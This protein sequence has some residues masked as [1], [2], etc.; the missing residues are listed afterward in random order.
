MLSQT[1]PVRMGRVTSD[2]TRMLTGPQR[3]GALPVTVTAADAGQARGDAVGLAP[4]AAHVTLA[5]R[6]V[7]MTDGVSGVVFRV[8]GGPGQLLVRL[9]Y[10]SFAKK[11]TGGP[12]PRA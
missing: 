1:V 6:R 2:T 12:G 10:A 7:D 5:P 3:A 11:I 8:A 4:V 9:N